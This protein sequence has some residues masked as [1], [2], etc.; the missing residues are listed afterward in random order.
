MAVLPI[1]SNMNSKSKVKNPLKKISGFFRKFG[2]YIRSPEVNVMSRKYPNVFVRIYKFPWY[3]VIFYLIFRH[4]KCTPSELSSYYSS[5][6][7]QHLRISRQAASKA[8]K[9]LN[10]DVFKI[11]I[12]KFS[13]FFYQSKMVKHHKGYIVLAADGTTNEIHPTSQ[14]LSTFGFCKNQY[15]QTEKDVKKVTS[16]SE[17][18]YD[19]TNGFV[20]NFSMNPFNKGEMPIVMDLLAESHDLYEKEKVIFLADRY[21]PSVELF[22]VNEAYGFKYCIRGKPNFFRREVAAMK[23][24]DEWITVTLNNEWIKRLKYDLARERFTADPVIRIRVVKRH[25]SYIDKDGELKKSDLIYFTNLSQD[26]FNSDDIIHLYCM[27]WDI[28]VSWKTL[29]TD[30]EW[31]RFFSKNFD[32]E[33]CAIYAKVLFHNF[34][35]IVR[36]ELN[37]IFEEENPGSESKYLFVAN[38]RELGRSLS[39]YGLCRYM[40]SGNHEALCRLLLRIYEQRH[41]LKVPVRP[42]RHNQRWGR[43][44]NYSAPFRFRLDGRNWPQVSNVKGIL[45]TVRP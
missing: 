32:C 1:F 38:I 7:N 22:A 30:Q 25:F 16:Q 35:G 26:E 40:R 44:V 28:E 34:N 29:K 15:I 45:R 4:E 31:E 17:G 23:T 10:P 41:K 8:I 19:V 12:R 21:Y 18:I 36:K 9:K 37:Q 2:K 24:N 14:A 33:L 5:I 13:E 39:D 3:D 11:L 42:N 20:V 43:A 27:R 6:G